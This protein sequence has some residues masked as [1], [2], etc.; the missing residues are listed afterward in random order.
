MRCIAVSKD[1]LQLGIDYNTAIKIE[2]LDSLY[3]VKDKMHSK[4]RKRIDIYMGKDIK[5]AKEWGVR[6]L[7]IYYVSKTDSLAKTV[8]RQP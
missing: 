2:G 5:K 6:K 7:R 8:E 4:W 3:W 1:L